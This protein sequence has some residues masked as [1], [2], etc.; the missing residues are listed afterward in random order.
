MNAC[1]MLLPAP[2]LGKP[3]GGL[4]AFFVSAGVAALAEF[5]DKTQ[6]LALVLSARF[7]APVPVIAGIVTAVLANHLISAEVG[8]L[9]A[10]WLSPALMRSVLVVSFL[11][12]ALW[13]LIPD[14]SPQAQPPKTPL[15]AYGTAVVSF[16]LLEFGDKT[17]LVTVALAA[18]FQTLLPVVFGTTLGMMCADV[19]A[20]LLGE[21]TARRIPLRLLNRLAAGAFAVL[22]LLVL[23]GGRA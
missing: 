23:V 5:G 15:G 14:G 1:V 12:A 10:A 22:G 19:P 11:A 6:L 9:V 2:A 7:R 13:M 20:V 4:E 17:Q 21:A 3:G 8:T 18:K 16:F